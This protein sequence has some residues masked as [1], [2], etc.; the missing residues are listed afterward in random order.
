MDSQVVLKNVVI[1]ALFLGVI[2]LAGLAFQPGSTA[3]LS[4]GGSGWSGGS[5]WDDD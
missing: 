1:A 3:T 4:G 5:G 2:A